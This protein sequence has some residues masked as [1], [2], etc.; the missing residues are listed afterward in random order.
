[1]NNAV[2][3]EKC[4]SLQKRDAL[5]CLEENASKMKWKKNNNNILDIGCGDG[6][7]TNMLKKYIP[8][9]FKLLGCDISEKM[10]NFANNHHCNEQT[11]FTV[12][13]IEGDLPE[14]MKG[15]FDHV[16][17]FYAL[18][19]IINQ[20]RAFTNIYNLLNEDGECFMIF[21]AGAPV[22]DVYRVLARNNKWSKWLQNVDRYVS[23]YHDSKDPEK[24]VEKMLEEIGFVDYDVQCKNS[25]YVFEDL[26]VLRSAFTAVNPFKIP[27]DK[28][29]DFMSDYLDILKELQI[30]TKFNNNYET[31]VQ[32]RYRLLVVYAR[33]PASQDKL[34]E[35]L[36][37]QV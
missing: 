32:F 20:K 6:S 17:S 18:H 28:F 11:S 2:L 12:L 24:E 35:E 4:N 21:L 22:F 33:K 15:K 19:W 30:M 36:N 29:D 26:H 31:S 10:V 13:D 7:V 1:M 34:L 27:E 23:P 14:G 5:L 9:D 8:T 37:K 16:F 3:Y 25:V